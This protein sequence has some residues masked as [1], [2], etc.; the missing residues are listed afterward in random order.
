MATVI[1]RYHGNSYHKSRQQFTQDIMTTVHTGYH[2]QVMD[3]IAAGHNLKNK[4]DLALRFTQPKMSTRKACWES[5]RSQRNTD[6]VSHR[7]L[8]GL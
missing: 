1:T 3:S 5:E 7:A 6:H 8:I 2:G 4:V